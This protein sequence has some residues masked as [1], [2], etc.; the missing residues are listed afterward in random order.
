M[1]KPRCL[2]PALLGDKGS[3][4]GEARREI[5]TLSGAQPKAFLLQ[6]FR[7]WGVIFT[8]TLLA[9]HIDAVWMT[10]LAV[11]FIA[12]RQNILGLL[13]HDQ[14]HFLG[15]RGRYG[16][17]IINPIAA[18]PIGI[19]VQGYANVHLAHHKHYFTDKDPDFLRKSGTNWSFPMKTGHLIRLL[20][21]DLS[22]L[23]FIKILKGKRL[24]A[25]D[26]F[27][28]PHPSP[29]WVRPAYYV[30]LAAI[31]TYAHIWTVFLIYW[32]LPLMTVLPLIVRLG[33]VTEHFLQF[34]GRK[35]QSIFT[36]YHPALVGKIVAAQPEL[37]PASLSPFF[38]RGCFL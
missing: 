35:H 24:E 8:I 20:A 32:A 6:A 27:K 2:P 30:A 33:A 4:S 10:L 31:L 22:G 26:A 19:T 1:N 11:I 13:V 25:T 5:Q 15:F 36:A 38:S 23:S 17:L 7:A 21:S 34:T 12:T 37:Y 14:V 18:Y 16:D 9:I 3:L 28:R 29:R